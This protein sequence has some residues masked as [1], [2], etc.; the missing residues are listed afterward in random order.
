MK[1]IR[2]AM[3]EMPDGAINVN[4]PAIFLPSKDAVYG[5]IEGLMNQFKLTFEGIKVPKGE[6]Y[7]AT[8]AGNGELGFHITSDGTG[9]P[10]KIKCRPPCYYALGAYARIVEGNMLADAVVTMASM[11]FI[12]GEFDR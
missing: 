4:H 6:F 12:A 5:N 8:E 7:S 3:K 10:Y 11:N 1:I 9:T 2:Q